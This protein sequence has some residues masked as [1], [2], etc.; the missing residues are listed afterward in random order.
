MP[1]LLLL[2]FFDILLL[3]TL[4]IDLINGD[5]A[6]IAIDKR[7]ATLLLILIAVPYE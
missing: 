4:L 7:H 1:S 3:E 6:H 5:W 2:G